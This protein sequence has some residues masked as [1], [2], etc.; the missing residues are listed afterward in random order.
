MNPS[1]SEKTIRLNKYLAL[2]MGF[3]RREADEY[4]ER[5]YVKVNDI[6]INLGARIAETDK[7]TVHGETLVGKTAFQYLALNKP[8]G[9][10]CS[11]RSQGDLPT[12]YELLPPEYHHLKTVGRLDFNS[13]GLII[14]TND[15]DFTYRLTHPKFA[16]TKIYN[17]RLDHD[18]EPLHQQMISDYGVQL[19]DGPSKMMLERLSEDDRLDW[20]VTMTE[21]R[22]RQIRRTFNSLGYEVK[23]LHRTNFGNYSVGDIKPGKFEIVDM[24]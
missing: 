7:V 19:E 4:I 21:G 18:L 11:R 2:H 14:L 10:V 9:Y 15:G 13:S 5:G 20:T 22:N 17:V 16:K 24:R 1:E 6:V 12:V 23:K 3:S 8:A